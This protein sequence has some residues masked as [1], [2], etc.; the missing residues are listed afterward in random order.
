MFDLLNNW[1]LHHTIPPVFEDE[2]SLEN[3][4]Q[5]YLLKTFNLYI[6]T[7]DDSVR[8]VKRNA[9]EKRNELVNHIDILLDR[10]L[11]IIKTKNSSDSLLITIKDN[12]TKVIEHY[13]KLDTTKSDIY[14]FD[15]HINSEYLNNDELLLIGSYQILYQYKERLKKILKSRLLFGYNAKIFHKSI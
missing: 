3:M 14:I 9:I 15:K 1:Y 5:R 11:E 10:I 4:L 8:I 7:D 6:S 13:K 12:Y 2:N